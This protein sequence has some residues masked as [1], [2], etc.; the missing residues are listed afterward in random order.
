LKIFNCPAKA[1]V[2]AE[3]NVHGGREFGC[4]LQVIDASH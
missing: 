1:A 2:E 4:G 3:D